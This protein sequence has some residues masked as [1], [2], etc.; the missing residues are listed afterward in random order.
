MKKFL[1]FN[2]SGFS[3]VEVIIAIFLCMAML[4][5]IANI[6]QAIRLISLSQSESTVRE[7]AARKLED[8]RFAGYENIP[9]DGIKNFNDPK[10]LKLTSANAT[11]NIIDC[12]ISG[13]AGGAKV[14]KV[15][16]SID[17]RESG[18]SKNFQLVTFVGKGGIK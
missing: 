15:T 16:I 3:F 5:V 13:C 10:L 11:T 4:F 12:E 7:V 2:S 1:A 6:P 14:K 9:A 8:L 17:W 18:K